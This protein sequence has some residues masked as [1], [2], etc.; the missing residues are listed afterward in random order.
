LLALTVAE[1]PTD[2]SSST[3]KASNLSASSFV[4]KRD[5]VTLSTLFPK[6]STNPSISFISTEFNNNLPF[7]SIVNLFKSTL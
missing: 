6:A 7:S 1:M 4:I 2:P 5:P 3:D